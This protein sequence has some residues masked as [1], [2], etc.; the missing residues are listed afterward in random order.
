MGE[1]ELGSIILSSKDIHSSSIMPEIPIRP[2]TSIPKTI[3]VLMV[4]G[5]L[6][7]I[8]DGGGAIFTHFSE[9]TTSGAEDQV[10]LMKLI[11]IDITVDEYLQW[12]SEFKESNFH[13]IT[14]I[15]KFCA[16]V[17]IFIGGIQL[18]LRKYAGIKV[19]LSGGGLWFLVQLISIFWASSIESNID[20]SLATQWDVAAT[21][22]CFICNAFCILLPLIPMFAPA[23]KAAL[24]PVQNLKK[25]NFVEEE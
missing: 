23:G 4:L 15:I 3:G 10:E 2:N 17:L 19:S 20:I 22:M 25:D 14:G 13:L 8:F 7:V 21:A 1:D 24:L 9:L 6:L 18:F 16:G 5:S 12:D 11:G